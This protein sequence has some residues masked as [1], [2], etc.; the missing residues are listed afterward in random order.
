[1]SDPPVYP[2]LLSIPVSLSSGAHHLTLSTPSILH[3]VAWITFPSYLFRS[4]IFSWNFLLAPSVYEIKFRSLVEH[5]E[6]FPLVF[7]SCSLLPITAPYTPTLYISQHWTAPA[8]DF[9]AAWNALVHFC[10]LTVSLK[11]HHT[12]VTSFVKTF[13]NTLGW[14]ILQFSAHSLFTAT[15]DN[16]HNQLYYNHQLVMIKLWST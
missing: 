4:S 5:T 7:Q 12:N 14:V 8:H 15:Y 13:P 3:I 9:L 11:I 10:Q 6:I 16:Y 1:M 2:C